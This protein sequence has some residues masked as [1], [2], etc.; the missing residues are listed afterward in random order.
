MGLRVANTGLTDV[1][2]RWPTD[3][4]WVAH[5]KRRKVIMHQLGR[6][7][8]ETS[9]ESAEADL[10]LYDAIKLN[11]APPLSVG[12]AE[13][14][15]QTIGHCTVQ[16][17]GLGT[18]EADVHLEVL[19][20]TVI[21]YLKIPTL[22][23]VRLLQRSTRL[24]GLPYNRQEVRASLENAAGLWDDCRGRAEG[25]AGPVPN[26]HKD[27]AIRAVIEAIEQEAMPKTDE[28]TF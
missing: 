17:V 11:G 4:E 18:D 5:R 3:A 16:D 26:I 8:S 19:T 12:E 25:Y 1:T 27:A 21:H 13:R 6:S 2:V 10:K 14:V 23:Q 7:L 22:D 9:I 28:S 20:G 24:L 15:V